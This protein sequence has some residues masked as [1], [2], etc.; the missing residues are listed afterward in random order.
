MYKIGTSIIGIGM[1]HVMK[2]PAH[3]KVKHGS[4]GLVGGGGGR[5]CGL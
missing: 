2:S 1:N 5:L 4:F 3:K